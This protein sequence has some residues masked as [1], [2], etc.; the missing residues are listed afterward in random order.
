MEGNEASR[1]AQTRVGY[2]EVGRRNQ[3]YFRSG[4]WLDEILTEVLREDWEKGRA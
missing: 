4:G 3:Q 2:R 1:K